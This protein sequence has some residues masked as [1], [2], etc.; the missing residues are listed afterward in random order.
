MK[1]MTALLLLAAVLL[2]G[3][4][5]APRDSI[6][7]GVAFNEPMMQESADEY[8]D[9]YKGS[10]G[11]TAVTPVP[12]AENRKLIRTVHIS[13]ETQ[14]MEQS[15]DA[16]YGRI[17]E[18]GGYVEQQE[19]YNG[20]SYYGSSRRRV[21][22]TIRIP[23]E[24][25]NSFLEAVEQHTNVVSSNTRVNDVTLQY[26][27]T[28][29]RVTALET[30]QKRLTELLGKAENVS[31]LL[32]IEARLTDVRYQLEQVASSLRV[33]DNQVDYST[34]EL[35]L[36]EVGQLTREEPKSVWERMG[37]G[38]ADSLTGLGGGIVDALVFVVANLPYILFYGLIL[39]GVVA[40]IVT[41]RRKKKKKKQEQAQ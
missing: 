41:L 25:L 22:M 3:C 4:G 17:Q 36:S 32:E 39:G 16:L 31:E 8:A 14:T 12:Q 30:E 24:N 10:G 19:Q 20:S 13:A 37:S 38:F 40:V 28:Q 11:L 6:Y 34:V 9:S 1:K 35:N 33:L 18:A 7:N 23:A 5:S 27:D 2:A 21:D 15:M 26:V 29:S